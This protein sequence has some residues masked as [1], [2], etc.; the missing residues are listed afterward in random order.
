M[1]RAS[2]LIEHRVGAKQTLVPGTAYVKIRA[3]DGDVGYRGKL[4]HQSPLVDGGNSAD[5]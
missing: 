4:G 1:E 2:V 3:R 5:F